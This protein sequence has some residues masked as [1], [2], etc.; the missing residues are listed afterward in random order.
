M[1]S[2]GSQPQT[3]TIR[4]AGVSKSFPHHRGQ[5][6]LRDR[7]L[8]LV[9]P[10]RR[11][12]FLAIQDLSF[13]VRPGES[14]GLIGPNGAGKSTL[15]NLATG[16][17]EPEAGQIEVHGRV[18]PL[19]DLGAGFH[20]EL[21]GAENVRLHSAMLGLSRRDFHERFEQM[22]EFSGVREFLNEPVRTYSQG[23]LLRLAFSVAVHASP[24]I[25]LMDEIIGV[26]DRAFYEK[27][28]EKIH[29]LRASGTTILFASHSTELITMLCD[30]ALWLDRGRVMKEGAV[31]DVIAAYEGKKSGP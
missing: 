28:L 6:L 13:E 10:S 26:G 23:M 16:L 17:L 31:A 21:T 15:L 30:K 12:R 18:T 14:V 4:F 8:D 11:P 2:H 7:V 5:L 22:V 25:L 27:A 3:G 19:L 24:D 1:Q 20:W 9:I 29:S